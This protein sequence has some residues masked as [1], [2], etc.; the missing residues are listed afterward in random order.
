MK[1]TLEPG[2]FV[3]VNAGRRARVGDLV[4]ADHPHENMKLVKRVQ[5]FTASGELLL[6]S[7]NEVEGT[8]S[9][10]FGPVPAESVSGVVTLSLEHLL[11]DLRT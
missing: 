9:R 1:P 2:E 8:D 4:V 7:D 6:L 10:S 11:K 3:L 5:Q